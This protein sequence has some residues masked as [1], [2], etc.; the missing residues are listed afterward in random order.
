MK[1]VLAFLILS[2]M[3]P[4]L[5]GAQD[6]AS[7]SET[8]N[9]A[10]QG[11]S[12]AQVNL[13]ILYE[14]GYH[15]P[16]NDVNALAWYMRSAAQGN[17]LAVTRRDLLKSR[18]KPDDVAAAEKLASE[19]TVQNSAPTT[20][21]KPNSPEAS[22]PAADT[23][24]GGENPPASATPPAAES[25]GTKPAATDQKPNSPEASPPA[26]D[27]AAGGEN[28]PA[29]ESTGSKPAAAGTA[30]DKPATAP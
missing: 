10:T 15:M 21:Q 3:A 4:A 20:D 29:A 16:K 1:R 8:H 7:L 24:A 5:A 18:M 13:G 26:A 14:F 25:T 28:P 19:A 22:P 11:N 2:L 23:A 6:L 12:E 30:A 9:A 17:A 27:T